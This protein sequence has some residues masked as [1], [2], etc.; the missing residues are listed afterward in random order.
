MRRV[1]IQSMIAV[2]GLC[3]MAG[4][5]PM[6][7]DSVAVSGSGGGSPPVALFNASVLCILAMFLAV[8]GIL[9]VKIVGAIRVVNRSAMEQNGAD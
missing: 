6:C 9:A 8:V 4:A 7:R 3:S 2:M 5:C 1:A